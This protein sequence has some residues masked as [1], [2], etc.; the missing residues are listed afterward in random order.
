MKERNFL[1]QVLSCSAYFETFSFL[2]IMSLAVPS[3]DLDATNKQK[4]SKIILSEDE[5]EYKIPFNPPFT[6][7][8]KPNLYA[9]Y[10]TL[11]S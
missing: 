6:H 1:Q 3:S 5:R 10:I 7:Y 11:F 8:E 2:L 4:N 9:N